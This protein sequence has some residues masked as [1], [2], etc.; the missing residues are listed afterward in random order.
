[1]ARQIGLRDIHIALLTDDDET[2]ATYATPS[3]LEEGGQ[4]QAFAKV[5]RKHLFRRYR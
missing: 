4:R 1:M 5:N 2:G 3:K